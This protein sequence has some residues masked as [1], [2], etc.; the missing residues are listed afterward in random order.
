MKRDILSDEQKHAFDTLSRMRQLEQFYLAGGTALALT[1]G[2][3]SS[4]DFDWFTQNNLDDPFLFASLLRDEGVAFMTEHVE[5]GTL[6]GTLDGVRVSFIR[7]QYPLLQPV[8]RVEGAYGT[9]AS[10][11]DIACMKL[12]AVTQR[13]ARKD[14]VD[15]YALIESHK[16]LMTLLQLFKEKYNTN[17]IASVIYALTY[18]DDAETEAMPDMRWNVS[19]EEIKRQIVMWVKEIS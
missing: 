11:D 4:E 3:R 12:S 14:F 5:K 18:F 19:W 13:G 9:I 1:V 2:H 6:Y 15:I 16:P 17:D 10:L 8:T 7:Y